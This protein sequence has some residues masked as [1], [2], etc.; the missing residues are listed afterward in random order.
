MLH[1]H[2]IDIVLLDI[3]MPRLDGIE[4]CKQMK[5]INANMPIILLTALNETSQ[6]V[7]GLTIGAD[8]YIVKPFEPEELVARIHVQLRHFSN[9][10]H[11]NDTI[12]FANVVIDQEARTVTVEKQELKLS[13]K[14]FDLLY[15][16]AKHPNR[17]YT[18]EQLLDLIWGMDEVVD[19]RTVDSHVR[20]VRDKL[21]KAGATTQPIQTIWGVGYKF[22]WEE[23]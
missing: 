11:E 10:D 15:L 19:I 21:K 17:V 2:S 1:Q 6:K 18:R 14:E 22:V 7:E 23:S 4:T 16:L 5:Q 8:D 9:S 3:M 12:Q 20:Y 13:P